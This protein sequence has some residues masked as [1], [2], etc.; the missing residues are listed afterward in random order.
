MLHRITE[1][2]VQSLW[3]KIGEEALTKAVSTFASEGVKALIDIW[4]SKHMEAWRAD[5][6]EQKARRED[7]ADKDVAD[8]DSSEKDGKDKKDDE[9]KDD[10]QNAADAL[11][12][13]NGY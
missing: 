10:D 11:F 4:K 13:S 7:A 12:T 8:K 9:K 6:K 2:S 5:F 3:R 1:K